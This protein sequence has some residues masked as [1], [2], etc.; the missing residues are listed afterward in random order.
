LPEEIAFKRGNVKLT[1]YP[2][3]TD[4]GDSVAIRLFDAKP[5]AQAAMRDGVKRLLRFEL[6]EQFN[7]L[8]KARRSSIRWRS[9]CAV[10]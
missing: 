4:A 1:G 3:L 10:S 7:Q 9:R 2:A 6:K 8:E 5:A